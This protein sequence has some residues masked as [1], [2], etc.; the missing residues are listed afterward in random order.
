M[1][2]DFTGHTLQVDSICQ[3]IIQEHDV[4]VR[5]NFDRVLNNK[6][7]GMTEQIKLSVYHYLFLAFLVSFS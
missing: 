7:A 1:I 6:L 5:E 2:C 4:D 3:R